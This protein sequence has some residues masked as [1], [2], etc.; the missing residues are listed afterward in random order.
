M[1]FG[2]IDDLADAGPAVFLDAAEELQALEVGYHILS[3]L[4][5]GFVAD[6]IGCIISSIPLLMSSMQRTSRSWGHWSALTKK[7]VAT[8]TMRSNRTALIISTNNDYG[9]RVKLAL[10]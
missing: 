4:L 3:L 5:G 6:G 9:D 1:H 10:M 7:E 8:A 2:S